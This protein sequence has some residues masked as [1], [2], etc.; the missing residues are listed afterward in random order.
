MARRIRKRPGVIWLPITTENRLIVGGATSGD[1]PS[2]GSYA[3]V[4]PAPQTPGTPQVTGVFPVV[5]DQ[6]QNLASLTTSLADAEGSAYRLRRIVGKVFVELDLTPLQAV[7]DGSAT[8]YLVTVGFIILEVEPTLAFLPKSSTADD[9]NVANLDNNRD[10]WIWRRSWMVGVDFPGFLTTP[11]QTALPGT[12]QPPFSVMSSNNFRGPGSVMDGPHIDAK[13][14]RVVKDNQRLS[15]VITA[16]PLN[17]NGAG[18][19]AG[20]IVVTTDLRVLGSLRK[21]SGNRHN[22]AR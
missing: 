22:A 21:Q 20:T 7:N 2:F 9:Y 15:M 11:Q 10:P 3:V 13:T 5:A 18:A 4:I 19:T 12:S 17:G 8:G 14:A 6:P 1:A 16:T